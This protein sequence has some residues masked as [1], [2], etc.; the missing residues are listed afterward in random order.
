MKREEGIDTFTLLHHDLNVCTNNVSTLLL[1]TSLSCQSLVEDCNTPLLYNQW[2]KSML[3]C[4]TISMGEIN[5]TLLCAICDV[6][7]PIGVASF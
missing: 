2:L 3:Y 1:P 5:V 6:H 7:C 4:A